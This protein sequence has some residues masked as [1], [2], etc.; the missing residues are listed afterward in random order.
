M[1]KTAKQLER[2][3]KGVANHRRISILMLLSKHDGL[4]LEEIAE[5]LKCNMK[6]ISEHTHRLSQAGLIN[7]KYVGRFVTHSLSPY[8]EI[9][10][11][12]FALF[13]SK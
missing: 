11:K 9:I 5:M 10:L 6:T 7:K 8:G 13:T 3:F 4:T 12:S 2:Y 1:S